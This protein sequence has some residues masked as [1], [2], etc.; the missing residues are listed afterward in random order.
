MEGVP[1][2]DTVMREVGSVLS[3]AYTPVPPLQYKWRSSAAMDVGGSP[4]GGAGKKGSSLQKSTHR[5]K[6]VSHRTDYR[7]ACIFQGYKLSQKD[8]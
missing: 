6:A 4:V 5:G 3:T 2:I 1:V 8:C 7:I